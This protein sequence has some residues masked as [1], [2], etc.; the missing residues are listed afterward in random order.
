[1]TRRHVGQ[2]IRLP[3]PGTTALRAVAQALSRGALRARRLLCRS[4][5]PQ[6]EKRRVETRRCGLRAWLR[7]CATISRST[8]SAQGRIPS[9]DRRERCGGSAESASHAWQASRLPHHRRV[10]G[11]TLMEMLVAV[12]L[13]SLL[14]TAMA[15]AMRIGLNV[16]A[17]ANGR[18]MDNRRVVGAQR[19][20]E[21]ELQGLMPVVAH[22]AGMGMKF[23]FFQG[24]PQNMR[25]ATTFSLQQGWRGQP[26]LL[27]L[28]VIPGEDGEGVRLVVNETTYT[29]PRSAGALCT[30]AA[31]DPASGRLIF[32]FLPMR[33]N[34]DSFVL[35]DKMAYCRFRYYAPGRAANDPPVWVT[36]WPGP[37][38][39]YG[40]RVEMAPLQPDG[41]RLQPITVMAPINLLRSPEIEYEDY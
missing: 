27:D 9:R 25:L 4:L 7:A 26:Q 21:Q 33:A 31:P 1:M 36:E 24:E 12:T 20:L 35:A 28:M 30:G 17:K 3:S 19:V 16:Y 14:S 39:P 15:M 38:W 37:G 34:P 18:L 23:G 41:S 32:R 10:A 6:R 29:G 40:I 13:L 5:L 22:C 11:V 8:C 2:A